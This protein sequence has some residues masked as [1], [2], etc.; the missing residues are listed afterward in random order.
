MRAG[1]TG[2]DAYLTEWRRETRPCGDDLEAEVAAEV[3]RL[4]ERYT[5]EALDALVGANGE[6]VA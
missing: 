3:E 4:S 2:T 1:L 5:D 6:E